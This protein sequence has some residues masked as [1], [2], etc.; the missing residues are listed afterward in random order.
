M[1]IRER[2]VGAW[3]LL[4]VGLV[5]LLLE[6][7]WLFLGD[8]WEEG[9]QP[10]ANV[11]FLVVGALG[12]GAFVVGIA[13]LLG[14][15]KEMTAPTRGHDSGVDVAASPGGTA[16]PGDDSPAASE[17]GPAAGPS[18]GLPGSGSSDAPNPPGPSG[19]GS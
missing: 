16:L 3:V 8:L 18:A 17:P 11:I 7:L 9:G 4:I 6:P 10:W 13:I 2:R 5:I 12:L 15:R 19:S 1:K 14:R